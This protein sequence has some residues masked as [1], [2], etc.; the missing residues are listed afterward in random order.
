MPNDDDY[1]ST[2]SENLYANIKKR[3]V[4]S[5]C[6]KKKLFSDMLDNKDDDKNPVSELKLNSSDIASNIDVFSI[7][8]DLNEKEKLMTEQQ[9]KVQVDTEI[10]NEEQSEKAGNNEQ[11]TFD[12]AT[13]L[14]NIN[15]KRA[16][17]E[18]EK[19]TNARIKHP[20]ID[21]ACNCK[22]KECD[23]KMNRE[24]RQN[25]HEQFWNM[26]KNDQTIWLSSKITETCS[27]RKVEGSKRNY[28][29]KYY[30]DQNEN[31]VEVCQK[32]FLNTLGYKSTTVLQHLVKSLKDDHGTK[33][34]I[35][36]KDQRGKHSPANKIPSTP[37]RDH[38]KS[39]DPKPSH[40]RRSHAPN[41]KYLPPDLSIKYM[42]EDFKEKNDINVSYEKYRQIVDSLN[43][44]FYNLEADKCGFCIQMDLNPTEN[45]QKAKEEHLQQVFF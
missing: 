16:R 9:K 23:K 4:D 26:S 3:R 38:I 37:I 35:P 33:L 27:K 20:L 42:Y 36:R 13:I 15:K 14:H 17:T 5:S 31:R 7:N 2:D 24:D 39:F 1:E 30:F 21:D 41:R 43:I 45:N 40:Y 22:T 18:I 6:V 10:S 11:N 34:L 19:Q 25:I 28:S 12:G 29:R 8:K 44:G 32:Y